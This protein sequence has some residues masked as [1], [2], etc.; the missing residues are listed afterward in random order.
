MSNGIESMD[1][2]GKQ[3]GTG[4]LKSLAVAIDRHLRSVVMATMLLVAVGAGIGID[5]LVLEF[6]PVGAQDEERLADLEEFQIL[7][8]T[9][10]VI[11]EDYVLSEAFTA[12]DLIYGASRGMVDALGDEGHSRFL[13]PEEARSFEESSRGELVG[14]GIQ[15]DTESSP[16]RVIMP[17]QNSPAFEAGILSGD[18]ILSVDG[19]DTTEFAEPEQALDAVRG[20]EGTDVTLE[21]IHEGEVDPYEVT[22]TRARIVVESISWAMLPD[23]LMW[24][25]ISE[26][27]SGTT[28]DLVVALQEGKAR[29]ARGVILD[30]RANPGGLVYEAIGVGSQFQPDGSVLFQEQDAEGEMRPVSSVGTSGEWQE[31]PLVV[32]ID[33]DSASAAEITS[34]SIADNERG[35]LIGQQTVGTGTVLLPMELSDGSMVLIG[36]EMWLTADGEVIWHEGVPP[37]IEIANEPGVR[38]SLPFT[39]D[40]NDVTDEQFAEIQDDQLLTAFDEINEQI[41]GTD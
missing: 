14:I 35:I 17:I 21:L 27:S 24:V 5:R 9:Y 29:G 1:R 8:E 37:T 31:G 23:D 41:G 12:E 36:T 13:D 34:S 19:V 15:V 6:A 18:L 16:P 30:L 33:G 25:R 10:N 22:L 11:R 20:D 7:E 40:G 2:T 3:V 32:L 28:D 39:Y 38:V 4:R 26:F